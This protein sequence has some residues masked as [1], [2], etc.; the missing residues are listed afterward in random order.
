MQVDFHIL[1]R[2]KFMLQHAYSSK[3]LAMTVCILF[4]VQ[5]QVGG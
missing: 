4:D 5:R 1:Q 3:S 2:S